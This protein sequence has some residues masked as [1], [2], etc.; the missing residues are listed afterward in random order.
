MIELQKVDIEKLDFILNE[1]SGVN[2][3][4]VNWKRIEELKPNFFENIKMLEPIDIL[5]SEHKQREFERLASFFIKYECGEVIE[6]TPLQKSPLVIKKNPFTIQFKKQG[7]FDNSYKIL[8]ENKKRENTEFKKSKVD[9]KLANKM[10]EEFP[11]T[12]L[13][14]RIGA[15]IGIGLAILELVKWIMKLMSPSGKT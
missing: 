7:G 9:L 14:S 11:K 1:I 6:S 2:F 13:F 12:K 5:D 3:F 8:K 10:L 4:G 15:F